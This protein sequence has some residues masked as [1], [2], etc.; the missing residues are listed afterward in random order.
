MCWRRILVGRRCTR[1]CRCP[2]PRWAG[3]G[4]AAAS[5][6]PWRATPCAARL[7]DVLGGSVVVV[8]DGNRAAYHAAAC[9]A[10]NH[11]VALMGQVDRVAASAGLDLA[12][13]VGL[14]R[15]TAD[16]RG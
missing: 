2:P 10:S 14:A 1:S 6:S 5:R 4:Y 12:A 3:S 8:E 11:V 16:R 13:F 7:A 15:A 9:I